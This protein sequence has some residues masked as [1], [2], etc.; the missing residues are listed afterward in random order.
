M[1]GGAV[2]VRFLDDG[3][4]VVAA[5]AGDY[6]YPYDVRFD[7][8]FD[9]LYVVASGLAGG[10]FWRTYLFEYDLRARRQLVR[11]RVSD[12]DMPPVCVDSRGR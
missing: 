1:V 8:K 11:R 12:R 7:Q 4:T 3:K 9:L 5:D 10:L 2:A 6:V